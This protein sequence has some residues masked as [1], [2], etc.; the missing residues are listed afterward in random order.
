MINSLAHRTTYP[1]IEVR[2]ATAHV[3]TKWRQSQSACDRNEHGRVICVIRKPCLMIR[4]SLDR[5]FKGILLRLETV[6]SKDLTGRGSWSQY[7]VVSVRCEAK[8]HS[9]CLFVCLFFSMWGQNTVF[10]STR[11]Q[12]TQS[13]FD[14]RWNMPWL[15]P[16]SSWWSI[17]PQQQP[18]NAL[19][20]VPPSWLLIMLSCR[21]HFSFSWASP[22]LLRSFNSRALRKT[23]TGGSLI[24]CPIH[25]HFLL[26]ISCMMVSCFART[27][28]SLFSISSDHRIPKNYPKQSFININERGYQNSLRHGFLPGWDI[29]LP[30]AIRNTLVYNEHSRTLQLRLQTKFMVSLKNNVTSVSPR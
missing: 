14:V 24:V 13:L 15:I 17:W 18:S 30:I 8:I 29:W 1:F 19:D 25:L 4:S 6:W 28:R 10:F 16:L 26:T 2:D 20:S 23:L 5:H 22:S 9:L 7:A 21:L 3:N 27:H 12:N 11:G